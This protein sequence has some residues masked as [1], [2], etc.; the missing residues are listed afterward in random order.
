MQYLGHSYTEKSIRYLSG[1]EYPQLNLCYL[2]K[3]AILGIA[4]FLL[5]EKGIQGTKEN[6]ISGY[7]WKRMS[8]WLS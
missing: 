5:R 6:K 8:D 7:T 3:M 4:Y 2:L 1:I